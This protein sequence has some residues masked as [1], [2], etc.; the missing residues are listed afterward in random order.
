M[1][2]RPPVS[3]IV[4]N[5]RR[6]DELKRTLDS[7][8]SQ[9]YS[10]LEIIVVDDHSEEDVNGVVRSCAAPVRL[11][12][13]PENR[14]ACAGR[15]TGIRAARG[16]IIVTI[17]ND[18]Q[19][20]TPSEVSKIVAAFE[21]NPEY[22]ILAFR[23][24]EAGTGALRV[25]E[26]CHPRDWRSY[27]DRQFESNFFGEGASAFRRE[28]FDTAGLYWEP[29]F[30]GCE[31]W[32]LMLRIVAC[33]FRI[34]YCPEI[35]VSHSMSPQCRPAARPFY[36]YTRN[37]I[38]IAYKNYPFLAALAYATPKL[39]MMLFFAIRAGRLGAFLK[40]IRDGF[41]G[42]GGI[43]HR[44]PIGSSECRK[45]AILESM[46][47]GILLRLARHRAGSQL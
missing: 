7:V 36:Y 37:Y 40:G 38:W 35:V 19:F 11:I 34:L 24:C 20:V 32:D 39:A 8:A 43:A 16:E 26:W 30:I 23:I 10:K 28:V 21:R 46:R 41:D 4:L 25:R 33:G 42:L 5:Y 6:L 29:L 45:I 22:H 31:G 17:D 1:T 27:H 9:D 3:V 14:G 15:N 12:E 47:P 2:G 18:V 13:L 44:K